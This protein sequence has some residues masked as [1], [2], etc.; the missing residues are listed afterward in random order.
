MTF[1]AGAAVIRTGLEVLRMDGF[2][3][4]RGERVAILSNPT[5]VFSDSLEHVVGWA[6][7]DYFLISL[8]YPNFLLAD[9]TSPMEGLDITAI[10]GPEHGFRGEL[11]AETGDPL[12][13]VDSS[14]ELPV[15]SVYKMTDEAIRALIVDMNITTV[16]VDMQDVG[17]RLYTFIWTMF[18]VMEA[19]FM[20]NSVD[21][22]S[23][24]GVKMVVCDRPNPLGGNVVDGPLLN[25]TCC[26]SGYGKAPITHVH[27]MTIGEL[28]LLFHA[29]L[30]KKYRSPEA[31]VEL[32]VVK[33]IGW[34]R[35][36]SWM[37]TGLPWIPP[38]PNVSICLTYLFT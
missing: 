23:F 21:N 24:R 32:E 15:F 26:A 35:G 28:S 4:L 37:D 7:C 5:G 36:M 33:M 1:L 20:A 6:S 38:S 17:V 12:F 25:M 16:L 34:E 29:Q 18:N 10:F 13:Y 30:S 11:Q 8:L 14:T 31:S 19:A 27:G 3:I 9:V 22:K 2:S